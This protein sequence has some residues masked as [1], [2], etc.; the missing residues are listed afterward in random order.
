MS[1]V[2]MES[3]NLQC[4]YEEIQ[5][6]IEQLDLRPSLRQAILNNIRRHMEQVQAEKKDPVKVMGTPQQVVERVRQQLQSRRRQWNT[7][8]WALFMLFLGWALTLQGLYSLSQDEP[9]WITVEAV[10]YLFL[11]PI[12]IV[13]LFRFVMMMGSWP[14]Q[15]RRWAYAGLAS[16]GAGVVAI[17]A[18]VLDLMQAQR[19]NQPFFG[20]TPWLS[21]AIG[22]FIV[23]IGYRLFRHPGK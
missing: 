5:N 17:L 16:G 8:L 21:V 9:V 19:G 4:Y 10:V 20:L 6:G 3:A 13:V 14:L 11:T 7:R 23:L 1:R 18:W 12:F 2:E 22:A 15:K